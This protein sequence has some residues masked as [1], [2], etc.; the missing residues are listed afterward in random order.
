[1]RTYDIRSLRQDLEAASAELKQRLHDLDKAH[2]EPDNSRIQKQVGRA[3]KDIEKM[4]ERVTIHHSEHPQ[5]NQTSNSPKVM[6]SILEQIERKRS[7]ET[8]GGQKS[9]EI[10]D[11]NNLKKEIVISNV[12]MKAHEEPETRQMT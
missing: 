10:L 2:E 5:Q 12:N 4:T 1:M 9:M 3:L 7:V 6:K 8:M 11:S